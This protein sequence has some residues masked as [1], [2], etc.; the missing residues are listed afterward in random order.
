M[1]KLSAFINELETQL[2]NKSVVND[3]VS[4]SS[5]CWQIDHSLIVINGVIS[6]LQKSDPS[7]YKAEFNFKRWLIFTT[8]HIPRGKARAPKLVNPEVEATEQELIEKIILAKKNIETIDTLNRNQFFRHPF[9]SDLN[10]KQT[11]KFLTLHTFHHLKII[12]DLV[13]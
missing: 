4:K 10:V 9:F 3:A 7:D 2:P 5:V 6:Q 8:N 13:K 1:K 11:K 12:R